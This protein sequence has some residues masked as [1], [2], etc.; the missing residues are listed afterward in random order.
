[1]L[2]LEEIPL[3]DVE[4]EPVPLSTSSK[5]LS[6][7]MIITNGDSDQQQTII[8][9]I[10][11]QGKNAFSQKTSYIKLVEDESE[12]GDP[13]RQQVSFLK[14]SQKYT[15]SELDS[16]IQIGSY[17]NV[18]P[19]KKQHCAC[20]CYILLTILLIVLTFLSGFGLGQTYRRQPSKYFNDYHVEKA[21]IRSYKI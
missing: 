12:S 18:L 7:P 10:F 1:M 8:E 16:F 4:P 20:L 11:K 2:E 21:D 13:V 6:D 17:G 5:R 9:K 14:F 19:C 15:N 3:V